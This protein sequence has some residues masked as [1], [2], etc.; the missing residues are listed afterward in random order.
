MEAK[1]DEGRKN[2]DDGQRHR[3]Q[4]LQALMSKLKTIK[5]KATLKSFTNWVAIKANETRW[6]GNFRMVL[7]FIQFKDALNNIALEDSDIGRSVAELMPCPIDVSRIIKLNSDL[8]KFQSVSLQLQ[9]ADG[10]INLF[11][12]WV[13]FN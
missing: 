2:Y 1:D 11:D 4:L 10:L 7:R 6:N 3:C 13:L 12:V 8:H 5:G 9:K